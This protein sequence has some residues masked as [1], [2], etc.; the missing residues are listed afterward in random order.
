M[1]TTWIIKDQMSDK[2]FSLLGSPHFTENIEI[3]QRFDSEEDAI[4]CEEQY[5]FTDPAF[6]DNESI[7]AEL[8]K[9]GMIV[10]WVT[11]EEGEENDLFRV[12]DASDQHRVFIQCINSKLTLPPVEAINS[13]DITV[14]SES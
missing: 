10:K 3:A 1:A 14:I 13:C 5:I 11:P 7:P 8:I 4:L 2:F 12:I 6:L 9:D